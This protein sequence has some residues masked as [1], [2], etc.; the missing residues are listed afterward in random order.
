[1]LVRRRI[2]P[3]QQRFHH[4]ARDASGVEGGGGGAAADGVARDAVP[5]FQDDDDNP[6]INERIQ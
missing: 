6:L 4:L 5:L 2:V 3:L 1:M